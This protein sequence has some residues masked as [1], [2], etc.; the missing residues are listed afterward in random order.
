[1]NGTEALRQPW[2]PISQSPGDAASGAGSPRAGVLPW[3]EPGCKPGARGRRGMA[4]AAAGQGRPPGTSGPRPPGPEASGLAWLQG[5]RA[6][7]RCSCLRSWGPGKGRELQLPFSSERD[8][9]KAPWAL[10]KPSASVATEKGTGPW[11]S[12]S[13]PRWAWTRGQGLLGPGPAS[14]SPM[15]GA[16]LPPRLNP[17]GWSG[18]RALLLARLVGQAQLTCVK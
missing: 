15:P 17:N 12:P 14:R 5:H 6:R 2:D 11:G 16:K 9:S 4:R 7:H 3:A 10:M 18:P 8:S 13:P 1:M